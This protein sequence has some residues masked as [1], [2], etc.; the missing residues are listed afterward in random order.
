MFWH[1]DV[2]LSFPKSV[3]SLIC[4]SSYLFQSNIFGRFCDVKNRRLFTNCYTLNVAKNHHI[5]DISLHYVNL[6]LKQ[7]LGLC[8]T[9]LFKLTA[10]GPIF[11]DY[12]YFTSKSPWASTGKDT[13]M[14]HHFQIQNPILAYNPLKGER[15]RRRYVCIKTMTKAL[16]GGV[17]QNMKGG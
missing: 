10:L 17:Q 13:Y 7:P 12:S 14:I 8:H 2:G 11:Q 5:V 4:G 16:Q 15:K 6:Q 1:Q 9:A 3:G